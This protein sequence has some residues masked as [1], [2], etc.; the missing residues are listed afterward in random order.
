[1]KD[2]Q[3]EIERL[4]SRIETL[5]CEKADLERAIEGMAARSEAIVEQLKT[6]KADLETLLDTII[7]HSDFVTENLLSE[8]EDLKLLL[9]II[10]EHGDFIEDQ[11]ASEKRLIQRLF[12][13]YLSDD[14][15]ASLLK[16]PGDLSLGGDRRQ[17]SIL[18][19]DLRGF[20]SF[21]EQLEPE[22]VLQAI[23]FYFQ[24]MAD[25]IISYGGA[26]NEYMG[27]GILVY[28]GSRLQ[29]PDNADRAIACACAMQMAMV[30]VNRQ[31]VAWNLPPLAM[32]IGINTGTAIVGTFGSEKRAK[33]GAI[34][35]AVNITFRIESCSV[36]RQILVSESTLEAANAPVEVASQQ[37][38]QFKGVSQP[39]ILYDVVG[40]GSPFDLSLPQE[41]ETLISLARPLQLRYVVLDGKH[42]GTGG[43]EAEI[44]QL[45]DRG[46]LLRCRCEGE[47]F[48]PPVLSNVKFNVLL[49][50]RS[51]ILSEDIYAKVVDNFVS[52]EHHFY[53]RF[54]SLS[55]PLATCLEAM[56]NE[57]LS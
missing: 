41:P 50:K 16:D 45:S 23:N 47:P 2:W 51:P 21:S 31:M 9:Q 53:V 22:Q 24:H 14:A 1:M 4:Q 10:T 37:Q 25:V 11:I 3:A 34:G 35:N 15:A 36:G 33:Y 48:T 13:R 44:V 43:Y 40:I 56:Q 5:T 38:V 6:E 26:I 27:D 17:L 29:Q 32:G 28:F 8:Q 49:S 52:P 42:L 18:V 46:A 20:T 39:V 12:G 55:V 7:N 54:T 30:E 19:S 57:S